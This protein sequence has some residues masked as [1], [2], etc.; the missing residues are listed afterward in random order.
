MWG[1]EK[2]LGKKTWALALSMVLGLLICYAFGTLWFMIVYA[3][4][5]GAIG[6][7]TALGWCVFPFVVPDL[8]KIALALLICKRVAKAIKID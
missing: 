3:R 6:L 7:W 2:V 5:A 1:M 8:I 4:E